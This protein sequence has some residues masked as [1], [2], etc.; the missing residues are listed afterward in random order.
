[1][2]YATEKDRIGKE[3]FTIIGLTLD[4]CSLTHGSGACTATETGD[5]KCFNTRATCN[6]VANYTKTTQE[7]FYCEPRGNLP[8][9]ELMFPVIAGKVKEAATTV[10]G[11]KGL[12][13]R[14][15][16]TVKLKDFPHHDR[17]EDPYVDDRTYD[18][19]TRGTYWSKKLARSPYY[20][21]R[22]LTVYHGYLTDPFNA[23]NF[24]SQEYDITDIDGPTNGY[25]T[26]TGKDILVRTYEAKQKW[27]PLSSGKLSADIAISA[28]TAT[29]T[30]AGIGNSDY[31][32]SG[33]VA[34]GRE[35]KA[36]TRSGDVL[37]FTAHGEYG[38]TN[39]AHSEGDVVQ[40]CVTF[41]DVNVVDALYEAL[42]DG[43]G[44]PDAY[45]PYDD[46]ATGTNENW[47]DEKEIWMS[48]FTLSGVIMKPEGVDSIIAE[49][50]EQ[51]MFDI[52]WDATLQE[53]KIKALSP[54]PPGV[55]IETLTDDYNLLAD[56]V[57]VKRD[58]KQRFTEIQVWYDKLDHSEGNEL[59][60]FSKAQIAADTTLSSSDLY[61][62][63]SIKLIKSR[64]IDNA[65]Q[66][67]QLA[68][69]LLNRYSETPKIIEF[70][71]LAKDDSKVDTA[72]RVK[73]DTHQIQDFTGQN[74]VLPFQVLSINPTDPGH[75]LKVRAITSSFSG[76]Y[77]FIAPDATPNYS[78]ASDLQK[79]S[80]G[81]ICYDTGV[82]LD[83]ESAYKIL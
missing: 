28:S 22:T 34:I 4:K 31:P 38:T 73:L 10:T 66:A 36:F 50:S 11:S 75:S 25:V 61:G 30:P 40:I 20:E 81:F 3:P 33:H 16:V 23:N 44:I 65:A 12:G 49:W 59:E 83:G 79:A 60:N 32:A 56:S 74:D 64:W 76:K 24:T 70:E 15:V 29:L 27:P 37:T 17:R 1:M 82:F 43:A 8:Q 46:G 2:T 47:D 14:G 51:F 55:T 54:E 63:A 21:G 48:T 19:E 68:G 41:D 9:G 18:P 57:K 6:D 45:I 7:Y 77:W 78:S 80:Y 26:V 67:V 69:R 53:V 72:G 42:T 13:S 35:V 39:A 58:Y 62:S 5:D 52:W 71:L